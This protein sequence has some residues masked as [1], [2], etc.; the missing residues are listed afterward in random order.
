MKT[1]LITYTLRN[2]SLDYMPLY[3]AIKTFT[4]EWRHITEN[5]WLIKTDKTVE[6]I[7]LAIKDGFYLQPVADTYFICEVVPETANGLI[8]HSTWE[9][10]NKTE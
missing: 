6:E 8:A 2:P 5:A 9:W 7:R 4:P 10:L 1:Y 3:T